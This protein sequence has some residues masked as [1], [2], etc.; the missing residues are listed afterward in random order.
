VLKVV[1]AIISSGRFHL[2]LIVEQLSIVK[3]D[4]QYVLLGHRVTDILLVTSTDYWLDAKVLANLVYGQLPLLIRSSTTCFFYVIEACAVR[5]RSVCCDVV[6]ED[7][8]RLNLGRPA[9]RR[10]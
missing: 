4:L 6:L 10:R 5:P 9:R 3:F 2:R 1:Q 8:G 7:L